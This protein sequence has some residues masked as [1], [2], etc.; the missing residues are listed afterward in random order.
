MSTDARAAPATEDTRLPRLK[1]EELRDQTLA[2]RGFEGLDPQATL[3]IFAAALLA[4]SEDGYSRETAS[5]ILLRARRIGPE[6]LGDS[7]RRVTVQMAAAMKDFWDKFL[8]ETWE[9]AKAP[10]QYVDPSVVMARKAQEEQ[11]QERHRRDADRYLADARAAIAALQIDEKEFPQD[12]PAKPKEPSFDLGRMLHRLL[13]KPA[14]APGA[15]VPARPGW[16]TPPLIDR[17]AEDFTVFDNDILEVVGARKLGGDPAWKKLE[18]R[19]YDRRRI[20]QTIASVRKTA[21]AQL[22]QCD[23]ILSF[24]RSDYETRIEPVMRAAV[25]LGHAVS[26]VNTFY[27]PL[28]ASDA[29]PAAPARGRGR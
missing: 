14:T 26:V 23:R 24:I 22:A 19:G 11:E 16:L 27:G 6:V 2:A 21:E 15:P 25:R 8:Q 13:F 3:N 7:V 20:V 10:P 12:A 9:G 1:A 17:Q 4:E 5:G 29:E 18:E 28:P